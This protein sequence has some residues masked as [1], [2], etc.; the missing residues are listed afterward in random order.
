MWNNLSLPVLPLLSLLSFKC[1]RIYQFVYRVFIYCNVFLS[2]FAF[3]AEVFEPPTPTGPPREFALN[4]PDKQ[5][6]LAISN[7]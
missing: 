7:D 3:V 1:V 2:F 4:S 6:I 5:L